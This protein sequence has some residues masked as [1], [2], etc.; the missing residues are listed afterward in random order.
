M[1]KTP[2][3]VFELLRRASANYTKLSNEDFRSDPVAAASWAKEDQRVR[4][5]LREIGTGDEYG[6]VIE[7]DLH[8]RLHYWAGRS[9]DDWRPDHTEALRFA[10]R[11]DAELM[12]TYHGSG[13]GRVAE[14]V[15]T[16][17]ED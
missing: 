7:R 11:A 6:W 10:R 8:S 13:I 2:E 4:D 9:A 14:H 3:A 12:L 15:W 16:R 17:R 1:A 5:T